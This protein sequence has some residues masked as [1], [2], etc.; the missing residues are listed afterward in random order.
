MI[1]IIRA[2]GKSSAMG[3]DDFNK[4]SND[5][6]TI[7]EDS[8]LGIRD[9]IS[10]RLDF[11]LSLLEDQVKQLSEK[12]GIMEKII[13]ALDDGNQ[14][15]NIPFPESLCPDDKVIGEYNWSHVADRLV[16]IICSEG[17]SA[18]YTTKKTQGGCCDSPQP[19]SS[20][21]PT[22]CSNCR[23]VD[24]SKSYRPH[25]LPTLSLLVLQNIN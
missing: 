17:V 13:K 22:N 11:H 21:R 15:V 16:A 25:F 4:S 5:Q 20:C 24:H 12:M 10:Q 8:F 1:I 14:S 18:R 7:R 19:S 2:L 6:K 3:G 9:T 23:P